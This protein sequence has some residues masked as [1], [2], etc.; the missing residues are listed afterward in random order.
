MSSDNSVKTSILYIMIGSILLIYIFF[1]VIAYNFTNKDRHNRTVFKYSIKLCCFFL[2]LHNSVLTIPTYQILF[3]MIICQKGKKYSMNVDTCYSGVNLV[4]SLFSILF[5]I[6]FFLENTFVSLFIHEMNPNSKLPTASFNLNQTILRS[7][8]KLLFCLLTVLDNTGEFRQYVVIGGS[9]VLFLN[10]FFFKI[11]YPPLYNKSVNKFTIYLDAILFYMFAI[12]IIQIYADTAVN[13][14]P[15]SYAF[16]LIGL[17]LLLVFIS[18]VWKT[19]QNSIV[20]RT[21]KDLK[22]QSDI[23]EFC[24]MMIRL[25]KNRDNSG[26]YMRLQGIFQVN[27]PYMDKASISSLSALTDISS[28]PV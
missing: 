16:I 20:R 13:K 14:D 7:I 1:T 25:I 5:L 3:N 10:L 18:C 28:N 9:V 6:L 24:V 22:N 8:Y 26:D 15:I 21:I 11:N 19:K 23:I 2:V 17:V 4:N 27:A 12:M